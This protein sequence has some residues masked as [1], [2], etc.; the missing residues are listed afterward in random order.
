MA[1]ASLFEKNAAAVRG[2]V[3]FTAAQ[4]KEAAE[5]GSR[6]LA[7]LKPKSAKKATAKD[8][9]A[10]A[11]ARDRLW[12]LFEKTWEQTIWRAGAWVFGRAVDQHVPALQSRVVGKRPAKVPPAKAAP[13]STN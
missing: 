4:V 6:L 11:E 3:P 8:L 9:T 12:T 7:T 5:V 10:A 1:L 2:K 13:V